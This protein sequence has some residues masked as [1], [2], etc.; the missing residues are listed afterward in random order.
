MSQSIH[1]V[2]LN[3]KSLNRSFKRITS[4]Q[5]NMT[6]YDTISEIVI[7][8]KYHTYKL[9]QTEKLGNKCIIYSQYKQQY[10]CKKSS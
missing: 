8:V 1:L 9:I 2:D 3:F 10:T 7:T 6:K 5:R 4:E